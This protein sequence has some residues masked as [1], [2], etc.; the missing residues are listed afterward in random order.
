M[1]STWTTVVAS[2][3]AVMRV[4]PREVRAR[5]S[6]ER[7]VFVRHHI[8]AGLDFAVE[9]TMRTAI[10]VE[11]ARAARARGFATMLFFLAAEDVCIHVERVRARAFGGGHAA[12]EAEL[13]ATYPASIDTLREAILAFDIVE[14][15]DTTVHDSAPSWVA[16]VHGG[17]V[18]LRREAIPA[19]FQLALRRDVPRDTPM[20]VDDT[21]HGGGPTS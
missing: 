20:N 13:R 6:T 16:S 17:D 8:E 19:W 11:Q 21:P 15:F 18:V 4:S 7:E 5:A 14:C 1:R 12:P 2:S 10:A 3:M 9:T